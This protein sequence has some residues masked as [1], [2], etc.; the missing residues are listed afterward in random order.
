ML[1]RRLIN[2][3]RQRGAALII[4]LLIVAT[5]VTLVV[6]LAGDFLLPFRRT[7]NLLHQQQAF[8]YLLATE[9]IS[10]QVLLLDQGATTE[11]SI[12]E[13]WATE[14][15]LYPT[16]EGAISAKLSD[17]QGRL[18]LN[19]LDYT[20]N[21]NNP[22]A[23]QY[24]TQQQ[25]FIRL[26][27]VLP[28]DQR[29]QTLDQYSAENLA[30]AV[31]DWVDTNDDIRSPGGAESYTYSAYDP[32]MKAPQE[33][34]VE[35]SELRWVQGITDEIYRALKPFVTIW[36][37]SGGQLNINTAPVEIIRS[38]N[39]DENLQPMS[40]ADAERFVEE[41]FT[42]GSFTDVSDAI[43]DAGLKSLDLDVN[44]TTTRTQY[45]QLQAVTEFVGRQFYLTSVIRRAGTPANPDIK[46]ISRNQRRIDDY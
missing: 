7:E 26:L 38:F 19:S 43:E 25:R 10:R 27:Q 5:V 36:P 35:I 21:P 9:G 45:F 8:N 18:N 14:E 20:P 16:P 11:D 34:I 23:A 24:S 39:N 41:R 13:V 40:L 31:F 29:G 30:N 3:T 42:Q 22:G 28:L 46:V 17:L 12:N 1:S 33:Q 6:T 4:A 44:D 2:K 32:P 15:V 37:K